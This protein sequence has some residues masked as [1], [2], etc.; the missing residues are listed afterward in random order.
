[1]SENMND[2]EIEY[3]PAEDPLNIYKSASNKTTLVFEISN[4][5]NKEK[6]MLLKIPISP[7]LSFNQRLLK[8]IQHFASDAFYIFCQVDI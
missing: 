4:V 6:L 2:P 1:M 3:P 8:C 5:I 7:G